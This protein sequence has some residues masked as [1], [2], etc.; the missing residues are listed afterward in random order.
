MVASRPPGDQK[1]TTNP[2]LNTLGP[3][4]VPCGHREAG[5]RYRF[6]KE[7]VEVDRPVV[8]IRGRAKLQAAC[9]LCHQHLVRYDTCQLEPRPRVSSPR[10]G[11]VAGVG[12]SRE[13]PACGAD[14]P[15]GAR[16]LTEGGRSSHTMRPCG[17]ASAIGTVV[18]VMWY[19][20][21]CVVPL[22]CTRTPFGCDAY[23]SRS[24]SRGVYL[25]PRSRLAPGVGV[26]G[27]S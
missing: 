11:G 20:R 21:V 16:G 3:L 5:F 22:L 26:S 17:Y 15:G 27:R 24:S 25:C 9:A 4:P 19:I 10:T 2:Y 1:N 13:A 12:G 7:R 8:S 18:K 6:K 14:G 23:A